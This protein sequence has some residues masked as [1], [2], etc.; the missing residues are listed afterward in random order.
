MLEVG[1]G[2]GYVPSGLAAPGVEL[3]VDVRG[4]RRR[5]RT[6]KKPIY[7]PGEEH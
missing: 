4:R 5:A 1:I 7:S 6:V 2:L 3:T